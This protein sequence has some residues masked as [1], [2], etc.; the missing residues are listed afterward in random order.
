MKG[1]LNYQLKTAFIRALQTT[2]WDERFIAGFYRGLSGQE[3]ETNRR[4]LI[5]W[6]AKLADQKKLYCALLLYWLGAAIPVDNQP[7]GD[8]IPDRIDA[9]K[10]Y[11]QV[12]KQL[13]RLERSDFSKLLTIC[14]A[15][16]RWV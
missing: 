8:E 10:G 11:Q 5:R 9:Q 13:E 7:V 16:R 14:N 6:L 12:I 15:Q 1:V 3:Q 4:I 2:Y